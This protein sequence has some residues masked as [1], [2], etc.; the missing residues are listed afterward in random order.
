[1]EK[2]LT[3]TFSGK[4]PFCPSALATH[5]QRATKL[6]QREEK[7]EKKTWKKEA[8]QASQIRFTLI[9]LMT[10]NERVNWFQEAHDGHN[11]HLKATFD[12]E[13]LTLNSH[14]IRFSQEQTGCREGCD[15]VFTGLSRR[16]PRETR[17]MGR[18][19]SGQT[20]NSWRWRSLCRG[21]GG[22]RVAQCSS[23]N[24]NKLTKRLFFYPSTRR[25]S[26]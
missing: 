1:M 14:S 24:P 16:P 2:N 12:L 17:E 25:I 3:L 23:F 15:C 6:S 4:Q 22:L 21:W 20:K 8:S 19:A 26:S 9:A 11:H 10:Q 13:W 18:P 5:L 7:K